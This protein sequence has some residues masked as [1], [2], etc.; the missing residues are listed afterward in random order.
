[1][2]DSMSQ[3]LIT[4]ELLDME[5]GEEVSNVE[6]LPSADAPVFSHEEPSSP[7]SPFVGLGPRH[8]PR[9]SGRIARTQSSG[10]YRQLSLNLELNKLAA[11]IGTLMGQF[12]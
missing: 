6:S 7:G 4:A 10:P 5:G 9:E 1:M 3:Q 2:P 12:N 11:R 8:H